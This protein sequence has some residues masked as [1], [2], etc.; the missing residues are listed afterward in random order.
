MEDFNRKEWLKTLKKGDKVANK[1][2]Y[3]LDRYK[4]Y[5]IYE[6]K[7]ITKGGKIRLDSGELLNE[8]GENCKYN[9]WGG[10]TDIYIVQITEEV[11]KV[12][13]EER[14]RRKFYNL[15]FKAEKRDYVYTTEQKMKIIE[16]L[17]GGEKNK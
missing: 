9:I 8:N 2:Y 12:N 13:K 17:E 5:E 11:L 3:G 14:I 6:V 16:L 1:E 4:Y 7:N 15:L 10:G